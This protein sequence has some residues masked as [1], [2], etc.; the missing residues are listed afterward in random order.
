VPL[1]QIVHVQRALGGLVVS[2]LCI[3]CLCIGAGF[4]ESTSS[5]KLSLEA[6]SCS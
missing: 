6:G 4:T 2:E 5:I 3:R 1:H